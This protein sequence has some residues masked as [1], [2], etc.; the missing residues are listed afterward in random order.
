MYEGQNA[1]GLV[2]GLNELIFIKH[3]DQSLAYKTYYVFVK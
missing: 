2:W 3:L 1:I